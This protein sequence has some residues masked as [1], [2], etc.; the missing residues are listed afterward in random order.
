MT[1]SSAT[2]ANRFNTILST[3]IDTVECMRISRMRIVLERITGLPNEGQDLYYIDLLGGQ[4]ATPCFPTCRGTGAPVPSRYVSGLQHYSYN[5]YCTPCPLPLTGK[6]PGFLASVANIP[7]E[8]TSVAA[9]RDRPDGD[10]APHC[11]ARDNCLPSR[12]NV[13][14]ALYRSQ[15]GSRE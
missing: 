14:V 7:I 5:G 15:S 1:S 13:R 3:E 6:L 11:Q 8:V 4:R 12:A 2:I 9:A 10:T